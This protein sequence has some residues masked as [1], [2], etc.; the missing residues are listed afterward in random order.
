MTTSAG[1]PV[2]TADEYTGPWSYMHDYDNYRYRSVTLIAWAVTPTGRRS[3]VHY[4][5]ARVKR[6]GAFKDYPD[7]MLM[8]AAY[9]YLVTESLPSLP[10]GYRWGKA[11]VMSCP[12]D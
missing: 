7:A 6:K 3:K 2:L 1:V 12:T 4:A 10:K 11:Y 5:Q 8:A 9:E